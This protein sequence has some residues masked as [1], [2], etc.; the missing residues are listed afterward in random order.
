MFASEVILHQ[1]HYTTSTI[2]TIAAAIDVGVCLEDSHSW[3]N[4]FTHIGEAINAVCK[5]LNHEAYIAKSFSNYLNVYV[6]ALKVAHGF[7][8]KSDNLYPATITSSPF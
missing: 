6:D 1:Q 3:N 4:T 7:K 8:Y 2:E 5:A